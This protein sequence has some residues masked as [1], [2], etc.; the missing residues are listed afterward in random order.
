MCL[1]SVP[2]DIKCVTLLINIY[3]ALQFL[4]EFY[5]FP[6]PPLLED[7]SRIFLLTSFS[8]M[9]RSELKVETSQNQFM[10]I[11]RN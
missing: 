5:A 10:V 2:S 1:S 9:L 4:F 3:A 7:L 8:P 11:P 6:F